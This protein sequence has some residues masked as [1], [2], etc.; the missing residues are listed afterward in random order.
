MN[1]AM[2]SVVM[3]NVF[4]L[5]AMTLSIT[6]LS[7]MTLSITTLSMMTLSLT[8]KLTQQSGNDTRHKVS[9]LP[10]ALSI[11]CC[12]TIMLG[13]M[14]L[15]IGEA[16]IH[17]SGNSSERQFIKAEIHQMVFSSNAQTHLIFKTVIYVSFMLSVIYAECRK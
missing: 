11:H 13:A 17:Q 2:L 12:V 9:Q 14:T 15:S 5:G 4:M 10:L 7:I 8:I 6:T 16:A 1:V 3:L